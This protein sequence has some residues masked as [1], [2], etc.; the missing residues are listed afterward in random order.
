M[1]SKLRPFRGTRAT[2][3]PGPSCTLAPRIMVWIKFRVR[4]RVSV[5]VSVGGKLRVRLKGMRVIIIGVRLGGSLRVDRRGEGSGLAIT[6]PDQRLS[7]N[8]TRPEA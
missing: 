3:S 2:H 6:T 4:V 7:Y 1:Y 8:Y 5:G